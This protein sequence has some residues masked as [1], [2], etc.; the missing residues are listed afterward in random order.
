MKNGEKSKA[1]FYWYEDCLGMVTI[2]SGCLSRKDLM[3]HGIKAG[4]WPDGAPGESARL[5]R[6]L[7]EGCRSSLDLR[8][9][10]SKQ[11]N[12][13][14]PGLVH[15]VR[16][17]DLEGIV[18]LDRKT[19]WPVHLLWACL[20]D[21]REE[22][23]AYG[24]LLSHDLAWTAVRET[25]VENRDQ[26]GHR[27]LGEL[28]DKSKTQALEN[29]RPV[30]RLAKAEGEL[31]RLKKSQE[32]S[33]GSSEPNPAPP[34]VPANVGQQREI[35]KLRYALEKAEAEVARLKAAGKGKAGSCSVDRE[36]PACLGQS[37]GC[38]CEC[39]RRTEDCRDCP[40]EGRRV[41][42]IGGLDRMEGTYRQVVENLGG[43]FEFHCGR[44]KAGCQKVRGIVNRSDY[45]VFITTIN[46]HAALKV[47]K[48][49]CKKKCKK[50]ITLKQRGV[51]S[52]ERTLRR[53][54]QG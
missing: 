27:E 4:L 21:P 3:R 19:E 41:A 6:D 49:F 52:L 5:L 33:I 50:F 44:V 28:R 18:E 45:V 14:F 12:K 30:N 24:R 36:P 1:G 23:R 39:R 16:A 11:I 13:K 32:A 9:A 2:L 40:L 51:D 20:N 10:V 8:K 17:A 47:T 34:P 48:T 38:S 37:G 53:A 42:V 26:V 29:Q 54:S 7:H 43:E 25:F 46:S 15:N 31:K 35:R 22:V